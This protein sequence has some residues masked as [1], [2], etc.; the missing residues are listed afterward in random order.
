MIRAVRLALVQ[1]WSGGESWLR[2][3]DLHDLLPVVDP[4]I[5]ESL[6]FRGF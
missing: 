4:L 3:P 5:R 2:A 1:S 6:A